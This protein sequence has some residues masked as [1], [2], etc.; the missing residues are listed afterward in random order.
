MSSHVYVDARTRSLQM[1]DVIFQQAMS[2]LNAVR[3]SIACGQ[4]EV[5]TSKI[6]VD[7]NAKVFNSVRMQ[8]KVDVANT[9]SLEN[10]LGATASTYSA[11]SL[12]DW[13]P[14]VGEPALHIDDNQVEGKGNMRVL[15][16]L[17]VQAFGGKR[18]TIL[19]VTDTLGAK[20]YQIGLDVSLFDENGDWVNE[21]HKSAYESFVTQTMAAQRVA[22]EKQQK[23]API[24]QQTAAAMRAAGLMSQSRTKVPGNTTH[25]VVTNQQQANDK[26]RSMGGSGGKISGDN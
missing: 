3:S 7:A 4:A 10:Q 6:D 21:K 15:E 9:K 14:A 8:D 1:S 16:E 12:G 19:E 22:M 17:D 2:Q 18:M 23:S 24:D 20:S 26:T 11:F 25:T 5:I 13:K